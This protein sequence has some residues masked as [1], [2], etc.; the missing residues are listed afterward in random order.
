MI[1]GITGNS[2]AGKSEVA[3]VL[4]KKLNMD[5]IDADKV[6]KKLAEP[7]NEYF[8]KILEI[9]GSDLLTENG[10]NRQKI[11]KIIYGNNKKRRQLDYITYTYI[12]NEIRTQIRKK[13][14]EKKSVIIDVPLLFESG[15]D[16]ICNFTIAVLSDKQNKLERICKRDKLDIET[17]KARLSIQATDD[18]YKSRANFVI[19]NNKKIED[20]DLEEICTKI[21]M[22]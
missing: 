11:A 2:G 21:G 20:L 3:K 22:N 10:F 12:G 4:A 6:A 8:E 14:I 5:I 9:F 16:K 7:G 1:I 17:A 15:L 13:M 19:E 18:F